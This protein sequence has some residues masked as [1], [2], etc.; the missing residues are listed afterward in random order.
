MLFVSFLLIFSYYLYKIYF[1]STY[2]SYLGIIWLLCCVVIPIIIS[3]LLIESVHHLD[4]EKLVIHNH[5]F[6]SISLKI[7]LILYAVIIIITNLTT[8]VSIFITSLLMLLFAIILLQ[9]FYTKNIYVII[10]EITFV[11]LFIIFSTTL[12][13]PLYFGA[14]DIPLH[15][16]MASI[17][18]NLGHQIPIEYNVW[19]NFFPLYHLIIVSTSHLCGISLQYSLFLSMGLIFS[20]ATLFLF[21]V[22]KRISD[23]KIA[24]LSCFLF[25]TNSEILMY[26]AYMTPRVL[27]FI[28]LL[29]LLLIISTSHKNKVLIVL[30][31]PIVLFI[32]TS[33]HMSIFYLLPILLLITGIYFVLGIREY[34]DPYILLFL[35]LT[36]ISYWLYVAIQ[37]SQTL[38]SM[39]NNVYVSDIF[40]ESVLI[41]TPSTTMEPGI[42]KPMITFIIVNYPIFFTILFIIFG[43]GVV[44]RNNEKKVIPFALLSVGVLIFL[45]Q[46]NFQQTVV[47][48]QFSLDRFI[49]YL[50]PFVF[51][52]MAYGIFAFLSIESKKYKTIIISLIMIL[53]LTSVFTSII[54]IP[55]TQ[56]QFQK[57]I[58]SDNKDADYYFKLID[59]NTVSFVNSNIEVD[60]RLSSDSS[61]IRNFELLPYFGGEEG[62]KQKYDITLQMKNLSDLSEVKGYFIFRKK[63]L[64]NKFSLTM[65][66]GLVIFSQDRIPFEFRLDEKDH[67]YSSGNEIYWAQ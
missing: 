57:I 63:Y 67:I 64:E 35:V 27:G 61:F 17:I 46:S 59:L 13:Y 47:F 24:L 55:N 34:S 39:I 14:T 9:I 29:L 62:I 37:M 60:S 21:I 48:E 36:S 43:I 19:Y 30:S 10:F 15:L 22:I 31:I 44:L 8:N 23:E 49:L 54:N 1:T 28:G 50:S 11:V 52:T 42:L 41:T 45:F 18:F 6:G 38:I 58:F 5:R 7:F 32:I 56:Q 33:H 4:P 3:I 26:G 65:S 12:Y 40:T 53:I 51:C 66:P 2:P 25:A 16:D 20:F